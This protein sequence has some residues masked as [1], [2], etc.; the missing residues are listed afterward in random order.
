MNTKLGDFA[1]NY[2]SELRKEL[3]SLQTI[4]SQIFGF[5]ITFVSTLLGLSLAN[6]E[7]IP[8]IALIIP[9]IAANFFDSL[10]HGYS[11]SIKRTGFYCKTHLEPILRSEFGFPKERP[12]WEQFMFGP[13][14]GRNSAFWGTVGITILATVPAIWGALT[15]YNPI[16]SWPVIILLVASLIYNI[17]QFQRSDFFYSANTQHLTFINPKP[18]VAVIISQGEKILLAR[19]ASEPAKGMWDLVGGFVDV[20]ESVED[21]VIRETKEETGLDVTVT[22]YLGS[23]P[24]VYGETN[25]ATLNF[26]YW[27]QVKKGSPKTASDVSE[28]KWFLKNEIPENMAFAH[29]A[30]AIELFKQNASS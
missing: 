8:A 24:D 14:A 17:R 26:C 3:V 29:Q 28:L 21:A 23:I 9:A 16:V 12:L 13:S 15:P 2:L 1:W 7:T 10:I 22:K 6:I 30:K 11:F 5:K 27:V 20:E 25:I 19:R 18:C 4:R